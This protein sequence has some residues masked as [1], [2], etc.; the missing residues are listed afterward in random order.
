MDD[1]TEMVSEKLEW[2]GGALSNPGQ[3]DYID[4]ARAAVVLALGLQGL[5]VFFS[6]GG[7]AVRDRRWVLAARGATMVTAFALT[8]ACANLIYA[9]LIQDYSV[10]Y[11]YSASEESLPTWFKVTGLWARLEGSILFWALLTSFVAAIVAFGYRKEQN[12]PVARRMEPN[13]YLVLAIVQIFFLFVVTFVADPFARLFESEAFAARL[14]STGLP[15]EG[16][17]LNPQLVNYWMTIHPPTLYIGFVAYTVPFAFGVASLLTGEQGSYWVKKTRR[18]MMIGWLFNTAGVIMGGL[19]AYEMLGWGGYWAWDPVENASLLPWF[20]A[21]AFLHS[22]MIQERREMLKAWNVILVTATFVLTL[23]GTYL[24]RSGIIASV[25]A[26]AEGPVGNYFLWFL[27]SVAIVT[28]LLIAINASRLRSPHQIESF[29]SRESFFV[30]NNMVLVALATG[31][32]VLTLWPVMSREFMDQMQ[33]VQVPVY[34][35]VMNPFFIVMLFL[36]AVGPC[37][38]WIKTSRKNLGPNL[39]VP[40]ALAIPIAAGF[41]TWAVTIRGDNVLSWDEQLYPTFIVNYLAAFMLVSLPWEFSRAVLSRRRRTSDRNLLHSTIKLVTL[42]NRRYGGYLVHIGL[43]VL[44]I[45]IV[46]SGMFREKHEVVLTSGEAHDIGPYRVE[47]VE[48]L[49]IEKRGDDQPYLSKRLAVN[50]AYDGEDLG[51]IEPET[52]VFEATSERS[53]QILRQPLILRGFSHDFYIYYHSVIPDFNRE[54]TLIAAV[55]GEDG[56]LRAE[57]LSKL[58]YK[59]SLFRVPLM[60]FLWFGWIIM[61]MGGVWAALPMGRKR[62]GLTD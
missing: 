17:G 55:H 20:T 28:L 51:T 42:N 30:V 19:W 45:G 3:L 39:I 9:F 46:N 48:P 40:A 8:V 24:T 34:N 44:A 16:Q 62:V 12:H 49:A 50:V 13:V 32:L 26:F 54:R 18:W 47:L 2:L 59:I 10:K 15:T 53:F 57:A 52:R 27:L 5:V 23:T 4:F 37:M 41:Q 21:T 33:T 38:G 31:L 6:I 56:A 1:F 60:S 29:L 35:L 36:T 58:Q 11:V 14:A 61:M 43:A 22:V 7:Q 25:H